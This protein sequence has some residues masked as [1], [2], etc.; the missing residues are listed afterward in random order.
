MMG[1]RSRKDVDWRDFVCRMAGDRRNA[2]QA[3]FNVAAVDATALADHRDC[4]S[5]GRTPLKTT[6]SLIGIL[7]SASSASSA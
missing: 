5:S 2:F 4:K 3:S 7:A 6:R 1:V